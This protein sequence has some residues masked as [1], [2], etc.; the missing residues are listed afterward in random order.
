MIFMYFLHAVDAIWEKILY[1][2]QPLLVWTNFRNAKCPAS[3]RTGGCVPQSHLPNFMSCKTTKPQSIIFPFIWDQFY[4]NWL[5]CDQDNVI[6]VYLPHLSR[7]LPLKIRHFFQHCLSNSNKVKL[8]KVFSMHSS[9]VRT[10]LLVLY[11]LL[12]CI[13]CI[14]C[15]PLKKLRQ[16][17]AR[18]LKIM[19]HLKT[20]KFPLPLLASLIIWV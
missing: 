20:S 10:L 15:S 6:L 18:R 8:I 9:P 1:W 17:R 14:L 12:L 5:M 13:V 19:S 16:L 11:C 3:C 7:K 4:S 2:Y